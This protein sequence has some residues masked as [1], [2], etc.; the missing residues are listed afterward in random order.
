MKEGR[1]KKSLKRWVGLSPRDC[2][3]DSLGRYSVPF[4]EDPGLLVNREQFEKNKGATF[5][6]HSIFPPPHQSHTSPVHLAQVRNVVLEPEL[7]V[8]IFFQASCVCITSKQE[9][10]FNK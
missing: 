1:N 6:C 2:K 8:C 10:W 3:R 7:K 5:R 9:K 4:P